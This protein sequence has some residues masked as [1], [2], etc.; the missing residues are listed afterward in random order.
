MRNPDFDID[1]AIGEKSEQWVRSVR[2]LLAQGRIEVK[3]PKPF[4]ERESFY[5]EYRCRRQDGTWHPSGIATTKAD[6]FVFTFGQLP[7]GL[8]IETQWL[9]RAARLAYDRGQKL[10]CLRGSNPTEAVFVTLKDIWDSR[11]G[12]P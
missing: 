1:F 9:K 7:G 6:V 3:G 2:S 5:V 11:D 12:E 8:V 4:L 10:S